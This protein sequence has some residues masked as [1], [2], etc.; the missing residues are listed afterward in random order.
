M[1]RS[2]IVAA[3]T[4][5]IT[6]ALF[7][8]I[9]SVL[10]PATF[11]APDAED[12][13]A[14]N[15]HSYITSVPAQDEPD[16]QE[17][18][19]ITELTELLTDIFTQISVLH[20]RTQSNDTTESWLLFEA[21]VVDVSEVLHGLGIY[22]PIPL[23]AG[24]FEDV[25]TFI[26]GDV[27][28]LIP[29][30]TYLKDIY[31][32]LVQAYEWLVE[33]I[34]DETISPS[35]DVEDQVENVEEEDDETLD[36][37]AF[38]VVALA[39]V[40]DIIELTYEIHQL[41]EI[42]YTEESWAFL[43]RTVD[44]SFDILE[45]IGLNIPSE[46]D[47]MSGVM[48]DVMDELEDI[49]N[50]IDILEKVYENL[51]DA[52]N[53]LEFAAGVYVITFYP[54]GGTTP[55]G[56]ETLLTINGQIDDVTW[57]NFVP[58]SR[59]GF[60]LLG[61]NFAEDGYGGFIDRQTM[62]NAN[63]TVYAIWGHSITFI[64]NAPGLTLPNNQAERDLM[65]GD[66]GYEAWREIWDTWNAENPM[67][68]MLWQIWH[69]MGQIGPEPLR[70][71]F[72]PIVTQPQ[73]DP[74]SFR[75]RHTRVGYSVYDSDD[76]VWPNDPVRLGFNFVGWY[77]TSGVDMINA[78]GVRIDAQTPLVNNIS[79]FARWEM[80]EA[81]RVYFDPS[82]GSLVSGEINWRAFIPGVTP[83]DHREEFYS[84]SQA[85]LTPFY[86]NRTERSSE[87]VFL[88][89]PPHRS[90]LVGGFNQLFLEG[91]YSEPNGEGVLVHLEIRNPT[92]APF[93]GQAFLEIPS[94]L[95]PP[96]TGDIT[97][98]A[99]WVARINFNLN[100]TPNSTY[101]HALT[102][103]AQPGYSIA[104]SGH[105]LVPA[106]YNH[107]LPVP[108]DRIGF[109]FVGW[110]PTRAIANGLGQYDQMLTVDHVFTQNHPGAF[111]ARWRELEPVV[112]T[113]NLNGGFDWASNPWSS[114]NGETMGTRRR[115][116]MEN[117]R[118]V[119]VVRGNGNQ[120]QI[121]LNL[122][123]RPNFAF[124]GWYTS[125][126]DQTEATRFT[127]LMPVATDMTLFARWVPTVPLHLQ[128]QQ[129]TTPAANVVTTHAAVG[130]SVRTVIERQGLA[131][132]A[133]SL[134]PPQINQI[135]V[136]P[137]FNTGH[138]N[139]RHG[140]HAYTRTNYIGLNHVAPGLMVSGPQTGGGTDWIGLG[141][142]RTADGWFVDV[143]T[144]I[145]ESM[146][147]YP[148]W[149]HEISFDLN[150]RQ[151]VPGAPMAINHTRRILAG[152][153]IGSGVTRAFL[154]QFNGEFFGGNQH[155]HP[156][157]PGDVN[158]NLTTGQGGFPTGNPAFNYASNTFPNR[159]SLSDQW[160]QDQP[161]FLFAGWTV[162]RNDSSE[163]FDWYTVPDRNMRVFGYWIEGFVFLSGRAPASVIAPEN[164]YRQIPLEH[165]AGPDNWVPNPVWDEEQ[166]TFMFWHSD[167]Y[168]RDDYGWRIDYTTINDYSRHAYAQWG[169]QFTFLPNFPGGYTTGE[170][171]IFIHVGSNIL[172][173]QVPIVSP[174]SN[175]HMIDWNSSAVGDG[176]HYVVHTPGMAAGV[177]T[178]VTANRRVY[179]QWG[180]HIAFEFEGGRIEEPETPEESG[181]TYL[182]SDI[183][184][185]NH[186]FGSI[187]PELVRN[188][189]EFI[190]FN[191]QPDGNGHVFDPSRTMTTGDVTYYAIWE[192]VLNFDPPITGLGDGLFLGLT[193]TLFGSANVL[194]VRRFNRF[195]KTRF[196]S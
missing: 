142:Y 14:N 61:W 118:F 29:Q 7:I 78:P 112:V 11:G 102:R 37:P 92:P 63:T 90:P 193:I 73:D 68:W 190:E 174:R 137:L 53:W 28:E 196:E 180:G 80:I 170:N 43:Q 149:G 38:S 129:S 16:P 159:H 111:Y 135:T 131:V 175:W 10:L 31:E 9:V 115:T 67:G 181:A 2:K 103:L 185:E 56:H 158:V 141:I 155:I 167:F 114:A 122:P 4:K 163:W 104:E 21:T 47:Y 117:Q 177:A 76:A 49:A 182:V 17:L 134:I 36:L 128:H 64:G 94:E 189:F 109:E 83:A 105:L 65:P 88:T 172:E 69:G 194:L 133:P 50:E 152:E 144:V 82:G 23:N 168:G 125:A 51:T 66:D 19:E 54:N 119:D 153:S 127:A 70:P 192:E 130:Y 60:I 183:I 173:S 124:M 147:L 75:P 107:E 25:L 154:N 157:I 98:Y 12:D 52:F 178:E 166:L 1:N 34:D 5:L 89:S 136:G 35:E 6:L 42:H 143:D 39:V 97:V 84:V 95:V 187:D 116:I 171:P 195:R 15:E 101:A 33:E 20:E 30:M 18:P 59:A 85:S 71:P 22:V 72:S 179:A 188:G 41:N 151:V 108:N 57:S 160:V 186:L 100:M 87:G 93:G 161:G 150:R 123:T 145:T 140:L 91:W 27:A 45:E 126:T 8:L 156:A 184:R 120:N 132:G 86:L 96:E 32:K 110:F 169:A 176:V 26:E 121:P 48:V 77:T 191:S 74:T 165:Y 81:R 24:E 164:R 3:K 79:V 55:P 58:P 106:G 148:I 113:F 62:F 162:N 99:N 146:T 13:A 40:A 44:E 46:L 139:Y 138:I